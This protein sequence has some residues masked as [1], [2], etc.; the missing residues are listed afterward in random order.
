MVRL[1]AHG[2]F[3]SQTA[4][5]DPVERAAAYAAEGA[6]RLHVVDLDAAAGRGDNRVAVEAIL[7][8]VSI[9]VQVAGGVRTAAAAAAW[10]QAGAAAVVMGTAAVRSPQ[11]LSR[12]AGL[13]PG[14]VMAALD[15]REGQPAVAG[16]TAVEE[17]SLGTLLAE[18][19]SA[20]LGAIVLT[21]VDRD[22]S[23]AG[24]DLEILARVRDAGGHPVIYS[25][26]VSSL[27]DLARL[28]AAGAAGV[29]LGRALLEGRFTLR[30]A[31]A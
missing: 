18:W 12:V 9:E 1:G 30:E 16:W 6:R 3:S 5:G 13:H 24:P 7:A 4:Y 26:G 27:A 14:Q 19:N 31:L 22:G 21:S 10:L 25:G 15:I 29:I 17:R 23:L 20:P 8:A 28:E 2:D 11:L